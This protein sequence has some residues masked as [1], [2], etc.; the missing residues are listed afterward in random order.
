MRNFKN[1][2]PEIKNHFEANCL[3]W[4]DIKY[5]VCNMEAWYVLEYINEFYILKTD[6]WSETTQQ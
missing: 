5:W 2:D 4:E 6:Q 1:I 3:D